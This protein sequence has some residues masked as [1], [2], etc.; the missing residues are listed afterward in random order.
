MTLS[1]AY[2][3]G[4]GRATEPRRELAGE[5]NRIR[6]C[7]LHG[8]TSLSPNQATGVGGAAI[9]AAGFECGM[10][11]TVRVHFGIHQLALPS[12]RIVAGTSKARTTVASKMIPA[13]SPIASSLI[14]KPGPEERARKAHISTSAELVTSLPVRARPSSPAF[15]VEPVSS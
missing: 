11:S 14:S 3:P 2:C 7:V 4:R 9:L 10:R 8:R 15:D 5:L 13:A 1:T 12:K 6:R